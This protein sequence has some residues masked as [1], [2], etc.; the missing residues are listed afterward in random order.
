[1][2]MNLIDH[3][4]FEKDKFKKTTTNTFG[5]WIDDSEKPFSKTIHKDFNIKETKTH[6]FLDS[7]HKLKKNKKISGP[8]EK[9][10][11]T[12]PSIEN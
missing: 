1:M 12:E 11:L 8:E 7:I 4:S 2:K 3:F 9:V 6:S 5:P 10:K